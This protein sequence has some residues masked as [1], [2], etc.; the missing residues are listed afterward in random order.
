MAGTPAAPGGIAPCLA[1][2]RANPP[3][4]QGNAEKRARERRPNPD[5]ACRQPDPAAKPAGI[6][7]GA[8]RQGALRTGGVRRLPARRGRRRS[9]QAGGDRP[10]RHQRRRIRQDD[11]LV[12]LRA[13]AHER[14]RATR[15]AGARRHAGRR[16]RARSPRIRGILRRLRPA[17]GIYRHDR[18]GADR[19][20]SLHR[21]RGARARH[22]QFQGCGEG[23]KDRRASPPTAPTNT[24]RA[25]RNTSSPS[26]M[27]CTRNT[28]RSSM[29]A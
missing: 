18:L 4:A 22:R 14:L 9:P 27:R 6:P 15:P 10:R 11:Q 24:T 26:P 17:S 21:P 29:P 3:R 16:R 1:N 13:R 19:A 23:R 12:T 28:R 5:H 20:H 7:Q 2:P 25:T 8:A